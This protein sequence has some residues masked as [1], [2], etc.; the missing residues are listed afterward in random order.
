MMDL[1]KGLT[2]WGVGAVIQ[3]L[4]HEYDLE[5]VLTYD[6]P[7]EKHHLRQWVMY[8]ATNRESYLEENNWYLFLKVLE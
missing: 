6:T 2:L 4:I 1:N 3:Y 5:R 7:L 8:Q